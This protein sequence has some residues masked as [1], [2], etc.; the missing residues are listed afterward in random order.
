MA[1]R[2]PPWVR[3]VILTI[4]SSMRSASACTSAAAT[5]TWMCS[6]RKGTPTAARPTSRRYPAHELRCLFPN[7]TGFSSPL[8]PIPANQQ[9]SGYFAQYRKLRRNLSSNVST[10][11]DLRRPCRK[12]IFPNTFTAQAEAISGDRPSTR[13]GT[14]SITNQA[15]RSFG[16][17]ISESKLPPRARSDLLLVLDASSSMS[18]ARGSRTG[19]IDGRRSP[20]AN[21]RSLNP[22][23]CNVQKDE[24]RAASLLALE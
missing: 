10:V 15:V 7:S 13:H 8:A 18:P 6:R 14:T 23:L 16:R 1:A 21:L 20:V 19:F 24:F 22:M 11:R 9:P 4:S 17:L 12:L 5:D 2:L 3:V